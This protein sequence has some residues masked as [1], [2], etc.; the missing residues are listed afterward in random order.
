[1]TGLLDTSIVVRYLV[2]DSPELAEKAALVIDS[3]E[4]LGITGVVI[5]ETAYV[6]LSVYK[7]PRDIV[8]DHLIVFLQKENITPVGLEKSIIL[9]SLLLCRN[10]GRISFADATI[11]ASARSNGYRVV[12]SLDNKFPADGIEVRQEI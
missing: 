10:S 2:G 12:F 8:V 11:W 7:V 6:L 9:Q 4:K 1:M 5:T 3:T